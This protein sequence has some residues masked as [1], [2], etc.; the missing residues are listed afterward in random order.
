MSNFL[1]WVL[2]VY[3]LVPPLD[4]GTTPC[5]ILEA[6]KEIQSRVIG[7][8]KNIVK[9]FHNFKKF[10]YHQIQKFTCNINLRKQDIL[11]EETISHR[12]RYVFANVP[13][14]VY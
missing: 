14:S 10:K 5:K 6:Q 13:S 1:L 7:V 2:R 9:I 8:L 3:P 4:G 12:F 11:S